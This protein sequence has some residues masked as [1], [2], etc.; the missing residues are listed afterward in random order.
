MQDQLKQKVLSLLMDHKNG[1][2]DYDEL[3]VNLV[4]LLSEQGRKELEE[5]FELG[6]RINSLPGICIHGFSDVKFCDER[7]KCDLCS[8]IERYIKE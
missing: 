2:L 8:E 5:G 4:I 7:F 1:A 3:Q 6:K